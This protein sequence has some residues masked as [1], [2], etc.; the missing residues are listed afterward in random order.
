M[1]DIAIIGSGPGG[2]GAALHAAQH[3]L[4]VALIEKSDLG[5]TCLNWGCIPTKA[6]LASVSCLDHINHAKD[7]GIDVGDVTP[8]FEKIQ[9][10]QKK[11]V[12]KMRKGLEQLLSSYKDSLDII[13]GEAKIITPNSVSINNDQ[14]IQA[15]NIIIASGSRCNSLGCIDIDHDQI[16]NSDDTLNSTELPRSIVIVG[17]GAIGVEWARI[18]RAMGTD[19][20]IVEM[21]DRL[22]PTT[23]FDISD[24][25]MKEFRR[26]KVSAILNTAVTSLEKN[27]NDVTVILQNGEKIQTDKVLLSVGRVPCTQV[28]LEDKLNFSFDGKYFKVDKYMQTSVE[29]IYAIG[30]VVPTLQ[31]AHVAT[32]EGILAVNHILG[33]AYKPIDYAKVPFVIYGI[34]EAAMVGLTEEQ[35]RQKLPLVKV[36]KFYYMANGKAMAEGHKAGFVKTVLDETT[37]RLLGVHIVGPTASEIIMTATVALKQNLTVEDFHHIIFAHPTL[38]EVFYESLTGL[39]GPKKR[40]SF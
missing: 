39:H 26:T 25:I 40:D 35:A 4:K 3:G 6:M 30:D 14:E 19:V 9:Q 38:S 37:H 29:G 18:Y 34:P 17:G 13:R 24:A 28:F 8:N 23:D 20:T 16:L 11:I 36:N 21:A 31:L 22:T 33:K 15:K 1:Y 32:H 10:R 27:A 7:F 2:Y 12:T 5:G